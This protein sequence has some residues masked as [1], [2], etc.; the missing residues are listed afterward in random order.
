MTLCRWTN[1]ALN[2]ILKNFDFEKEFPATA[3]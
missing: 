3:K 2:V 1:A